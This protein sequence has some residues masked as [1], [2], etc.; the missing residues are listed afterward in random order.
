MALGEWTRRIRKGVISGGEWLRPHDG[1]AAAI[2]RVRR[3]V[4]GP[5]QTLARGFPGSGESAAWRTKLGASLI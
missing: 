1:E 4:P 2:Q 5:Q 3:Q